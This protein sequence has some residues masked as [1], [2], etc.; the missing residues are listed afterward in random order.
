VVGGPRVCLEASWAGAEQN[1]SD[2]RWTSVGRV[3]SV[4]CTVVGPIVR[5][6]RG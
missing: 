4:G 1:D 6:E 3:G 5:L 2:R